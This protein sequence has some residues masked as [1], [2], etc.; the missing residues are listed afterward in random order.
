MAVCRWLCAASLLIGLC[1]P[2]PAS[3]Q[4]RAGTITGTVLDSSKALVPGASVVVT[5]EATSIATSLLTNEAGQFTALYLPAGTYKIEVSLAGFG[6]YRRTG[7][8]LAPTDTVRIPVELAP[9]R[10]GETVDVAAE[11]PRLQTDRSNVSGAVGSDMIEALPNITQNPLQYA[12]LQAGAIGRNSTADTTGLN[13]F[14]IGVD[15]RRNWSAVGVNGGRAFTNDIQLDGLPVMGGGYNEAAVVPNTEGLQEVR[16]ISNNFSAEYG[17]GQAIIS[18]STK[19]GTNA[20]RG[21]G[22]YLMRNEALDANTFSNNARAIAKRQFRVQDVGGSLGGPILHNRL[23]F[24]SSYHGLRNNQGQTTMA[25]VPTALERAGNFSQTF[26]RNESGL[27]VPAQIFDPYNVVQE[28]PDLYRRLPIPNAIIP[29]PNAAALRM[30]AFYPLPN[31]APD[32]VF[33]TNNFEANTVLTVRRQSSNNRVDWRAGRH[34]IYASAGISYATITTPRP[35]GVTPFNGAPGIRSD[36]NPYFQVGDAVVLSPSLVVDVRYGVT[37]I[38][39]KSFTGDKT[40]FKD[41]TAFGVP[42]NLQPFMAFPEAAPVVNPNGFSGGQGGGSNWTALS[43][44]TFGT[45]LEV[46]TSQNFAGSITKIRGAWT[47]KAGTEYRNLL[48]HYADPEQASV[49]IPS[50]TA[51]TGGN[52]NFEYT[53]ADGN[54][55]SLTRTNAQ[56][57][58]NGAAMLLGAGLWTIRPGANVLPYFSQKYFAIYSQNDWRASSKLTINLGLRWEL[59]PG[60]TERKNRMSAWDFSRQN[61]FGTPGA[62]AFPGVGGYSRNLWDTEYN[63]WG[64]RVGAAYTINSRTVVR[65]GFGITYLPSN[66]GYFSGPTDYGSANFSGGVSQ[67]PYGLTPRGVPAG[68]FSDP[69]PLVPATGGEPTAP[70]V[71]GIGE[72][73][74]D[75]H[76][77]NGRST[78]WNVF[79]ERSI[80]RN[81]MVSAGYTASA[82]RNLLNRS[83]PIQNL[84]SVPR[85]VLDQW[86]AQYIASNGTLNPATQL[87]PNP[88]QPASGSLLPFAGV[89]GA[90]TI[91]R[92]NT[93]FPYPLLIGSGAAVN[94]TGATA[95]F[96]SVQLRLGRRFA[97]GLMADASYTWSRNWEDTDTGIEDG[98]GFNAGGTARNYDLYHPEANRTLGLTD[99]PHRLIATFLYKVSIAGT[100]SASR[101]VLKAVAADWQL[102]GTVVWQSGFPIAISGAS[103]GAALARPDRI[104]G[105]DLVL[106]Q[107]L[108]GW[109]D[110]KTAVTLPS[111]RVITPPAF[112]YLKYNPDAFAGRVV[113][114]P[115]GSI[116]ADQYWFGNAAQTY[117]EIRTDPRFNIDASV[118]RQFRIARYQLEIGADIMNLLNHTQFNGAYAG[119]LGG[120]TT[121]ANA[122]LGIKPGM[123][124]ANNY[125][126]RGMGT[127]NPRQM[128]LRAT[129]RF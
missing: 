43:A 70:Q 16:V 114:T 5:N 94:R 62:I 116:V 74:F 34:S 54:S 107:S 45:K 108:W 17:R 82:S 39:T 78:Q 48:S 127:F 87:I 59:Q 85:D 80:A 96:K 84:Q 21:Q 19:A 120:T 32:D 37:H 42:A 31:R 53:T 49:A 128:M 103:T 60:P 40:G 51:H 89:L 22:S 3:A 97:N 122:A 91:A 9:A 111:G 106:P 95:D 63:D 118:R 14:G 72:S 1:H 33:N 81:W 76:F 73:R 93:Y 28:G 125:G 27:P 129:L 112:T 20:F 24:F 79:L 46:Q 117:D 123:G 124:N 65:G 119:G 61:A 25:T 7:V 30:L 99:V 88:Y 23:F 41:F 98:Q 92:S 90:S 8:A 29:G 71:Y 77:H 83:F 104:P 36:N 100:G 52:F 35:F 57:G 2:S 55:A 18:M 10:V 13:S 67:I 121:T 126:T 113:A 12:M 58:V 26:I 47:H 105:I 6:T 15:G 66:T 44:G 115:N 4:I 101:R 50:P 64:P 75:R 102:G 68:F 56:R 69:S 11:A 38:D 109:Y 86:R 110:G